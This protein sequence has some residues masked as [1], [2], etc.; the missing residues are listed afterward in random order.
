M[1]TGQSG[2]GEGNGFRLKDGLRTFLYRSG[3][4]RLFG[5]RRIRHALTVVM[6]H[7]VLPRDDP[8]WASADPVYTMDL[9]VFEAFLDWARREFRPVCLP[10]LQEAAGSGA[11]LPPRSLL[12]TLDDGWY[13]TPR[14]AAPAL[15]ARGIPGLLFVTSGAVDH[16]A[17]LWR[18]VAAILARAGALA[19]P[20]G[21]PDAIAP[22]LASMPAAGRDALLTGILDR[23]GHLRPLMMQE[24]AFPL[25][26]AAGVAVGGH[27]VT[28][29]P[30]T[31]APDPESELMGCRS[32]L[33]RA[34]G[35][36]ISSFAFPHGRY[37]P[38]LLGKAFAA[39]FR[40]LFTSDS[41]LNSLEGQRPASP[42]F[43]RIAISQ[44]DITDGDGWFSPERALFFLMNRRSAVLDGKRGAFPA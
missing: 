4:A 21:S 9:A 42:V 31:E 6:F 17:T 41:V 8:R 7:R 19:A 3:A 14:Y 43:G 30:L 44:Q 15:K 26:A 29:T 20:G 24:A 12:I 13:D 1:R 37:S 23:T 36:E 40:F 2:A 35:A 22:W 10:M 27:G 34:A 11:P 33:A 18:D 39:G 28:H 5:R 38:D 16:D 32:A 25:L